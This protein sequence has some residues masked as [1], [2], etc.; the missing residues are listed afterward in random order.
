MNQ[1]QLA[2]TPQDEKNTK[3]NLDTILEERVARTIDEILAV[4]LKVLIDQLEGYMQGLVRESGNQILGAV[5]EHFSAFASNI[6]DPMQQMAK[7]TQEM[8]EQINSIDVETA[9][10]SKA[11]QKNGNVSLQELIEAN[12]GVV[13]Q[14][15]FAMKVADKAREIE[16]NLPV[17]QESLAK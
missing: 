7:K 1:N 3:K 8:A 15:E 5:D 9:T 2:T 16:S 12:K 17:G 11:L 14:M 4:R 13:E 6:T 10:L